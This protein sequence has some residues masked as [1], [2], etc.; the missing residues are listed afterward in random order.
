LK[1]KPVQIYD[2][3]NILAGSL[4]ANDRQALD[5]DTQLLAIEDTAFFQGAA[6]GLYIDDRTQELPPQVLVLRPPSLIAGIGC[7]RHTGMDE[8]KGLLQTVMDAHRLS[9]HSLVQLASIDLKK[10][11]AGLLALGRAWDIPLV[12]YGKDQL[13][14]VQDQ[15]TPS[16]IVEKHVGVKSVCEAAAIL[17]AAQGKLIVPKHATRNVTVAIARKSYTS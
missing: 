14:Q 5:R 11:E 10:D 13:K 8:I 4:P 6:A 7:N 15:C 9:S 12:F 3:F 2:P 17:A 16:K 1:K